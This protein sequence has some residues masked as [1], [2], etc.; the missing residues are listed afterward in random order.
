[1][2]THT[3]HSHGA[4]G[5]HDA[6][7]VHVVPVKVLVAVAAALLVLTVVTVAVTYVDLGPW[8]LWVAL[9]VAVVKGS[10]VV[11]YFM[12]LRYDNPFNAFLF[13]C[14]LGFVALLLALALIDRD[15]YEPALIPGYAPKIEAARPKP[16]PAAPAAAT[17][18]PAA[19]A[20]SPAAQA[21]PQGATPVGPAPGAPPPQPPHSP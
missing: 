19:P 21:A 15:V 13:A 7:D 14:S 16:A 2:S 12:H 10:L 4:H 3:E 11:M 18:A 1:M 20:G 5:A 8:N 17:P 6:H 9:A